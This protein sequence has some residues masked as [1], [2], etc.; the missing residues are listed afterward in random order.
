MFLVY[1]FMYIISSRKSKKWLQLQFQQWFQ[2]QFQQWLQLQTASQGSILSNYAL[3]QIDQSLSV[4]GHITAL[5]HA[6][7]SFIMEIVKCADSG[8]QPISHCSENTC[9]IKHCRRS[10]LA[11]LLTYYRYY[12][13]KHVYIVGTQRR[14]F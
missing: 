14:L 1:L 6:F 2:L 10:H 8:R 11:N 3:D 9:L 12:T 4:F 13:C 5:L 7:L